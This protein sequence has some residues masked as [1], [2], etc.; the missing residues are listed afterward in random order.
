MQR[1]EFEDLRSALQ[2]YEVLNEQFFTNRQHFPNVRILGMDNV[3]SLLKKAYTLSGMVLYKFD[4]ETGFGMSTKTFVIAL[5]SDPQM[6]KNVA[7]LSPGYVDKEEL[8]ISID[9]RILNYPTLVSFNDES[10]SK[11]YIEERDLGFE[12]LAARLNCLAPYVNE[13]FI[14]EHLLTEATERQASHV[15]LQ[16]MA[17]DIHGTVQKL[18]GQQETRSPEIFNRGFKIPPVFQ[19]LMAQTENLTNPHVR[20][21]TLPDKITEEHLKDVKLFSRDT[22]TSTTDESDGVKKL[23]GVAEI[24]TPKPVES[25]L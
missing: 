14:K 18:M 25:S 17:D 16:G 23:E 19:K 12:L 11:W 21:Y 20:V 9:T 4:R 3:H 13:D 10:P 6:E 7:F 24:L 5:I 1:L 8:V 2:T 15:V 22:I